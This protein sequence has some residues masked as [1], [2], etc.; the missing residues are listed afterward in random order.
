[1]IKWRFLVGR[2]TIFFLSLPQ[3][4]VDLEAARPGPSNRA[5][6]PVLGL[7]RRPHRNC[8]QDISHSV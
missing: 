5:S 6:Q 7:V 2:L 1:M 4:C 8:E 3:P